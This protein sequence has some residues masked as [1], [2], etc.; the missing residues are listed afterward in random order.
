MKIK[1]KEYEK[2]ISESKIEAKTISMKQ[3]KKILKDIE[4]KREALEK[5]LIMK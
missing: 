3:E 2:I 5:K 1:I 4:I